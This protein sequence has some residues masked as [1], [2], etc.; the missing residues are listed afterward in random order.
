MSPRLGRK[1][2]RLRSS[3][4]GCLTG[5]QIK[6]K[7]ARNNPKLNSHL[8]SVRQQLASE[9]LDN[10]VLAQVSNQLTEISFAS[11]DS[12]GDAVRR[13]AELLAVVS[14]LAATWDASTRDDPTDRSELINF[15]QDG[16]MVLDDAINTGECEEE[17]LSFIDLANENWS[18]YLSLFD[19]SRFVDN[20]REIEWETSGA[21]DNNSQDEI[22]DS[23]QIAMMLQ[24]LSG[25]G[26]D[27]AKGQQ[28]L[29]EDADLE[30]PKT[31]KAS[32]SLKAANGFIPLP[33]KGTDVSA[34]RGLA[35]DPEM[36]EAY[37]DDALRCVASMEQASMQVEQDASDHEPV[38][39]F[40]R[41]L[42][43]LKG[44]SATVG[45]AELAAYL[46]DLE[47]SL[48][49]IFENQTVTADA[50][51]LFAAV[52]QVRSLVESLQP[53]S[54]IVTVSD[55]S[56][57]SVAGPANEFS[58]FAS[59][60][61]ASIRIRASKLDRL[62]DMLAELVVLRNHQE[63][64]I[65]D[66][67]ELNEELTRCSA[68][69]S[70]TNERGNLTL[71]DEAIFSHSTE[72][73][74]PSA[75]LSEVSKDIA[76]VSQGLRDLQKPISQNSVSITR[77][78]RDFRQ[79]LMQ[80]RRVPVSGMFTRLQRAARDAAKS[81][82]KKVRIELIGENAGLEQEIQERLFESLLHVVRNS[83]SHGIESEKERIKLGKDSVGT[84]TLEATSNAQLLIIEVRDDGGG[85]DYEAV[86][87]RATEKGLI[88][89]G[90]D[91]S[92][93]ELGKLIF[94]PGFSTRETASAV[95]GRGVGMDIVATTIGQLK[96]RIEVDSE[97]KLGTTIRILIPLKSGIEHV[98]VFR[99]GQQLFALPMEAVSSVKRETNKNGV[100]IAQLFGTESQPANDKGE[101]LHIRRSNLQ[102]S[103]SKK[104]LALLVDELLGPEEVVVRKL[105]NLLRQH[106][107]FDGVTLS[108]S[109]KKVLLLDAEQFADHCEHAQ[110][111]DSDSIASGQADLDR[112]VA[113]V[114]D[115]S[116]TARRALS[117]AL[118]QF[119][120]HVTEAG[121]GQQALE[122]LRNQTFDL[123]MTDLDMPRMGGLELL[124][125]MQSGNYCDAPKIVVSSRNEQTF[126]DQALEVGADEYITKPI[127]KAS[128]EQL[129]V[130]LELSDSVEGQSR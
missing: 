76:A 32:S 81:E 36:L 2:K 22:P 58:S 34:A 87:K 7:K 109:G 97:R 68:R 18:D 86:R 70:V 83:V 61:D 85:I 124:S 114:V 116:L 105:P 102:R 63:S 14:E 39:Q 21:Q 84:I 15:L 20:A 67:D 117:K 23:G 120:F 59:T 51:Q 52:D 44:A 64:D 11:D 79:E 89:A 29:N 40:C 130:S 125:D 9:S 56:V 62:M 4:S 57:A 69:I 90:H 47:S 95:S 88:A 82:T 49:S 91:A 54:E 113:L 74:Q 101:V 98:M 5:S 65:A 93:S 12:T 35:N 26:D 78:I 115:D 30:L 110:A 94:H 106:P 127:S 1:S 25:G 121:D 45:L 92:Q 123:V 41:E 66:F 55:S 19:E 80:L 3:N 43:T 103:P 24:A 27:D 128:I 99:S 129:L 77:F 108:G 118:R 71:A 46:H 100:S 31:S 6:M 60:D 119:G 8:D 13:G 17:I 107:F 48:E 10:R 28:S 126:K 38:R 72:L 16:V 37:L 33:P 50:E 104:T 73:G 122:L 75:V 111:D 42:H 53:S 96:G 112:R